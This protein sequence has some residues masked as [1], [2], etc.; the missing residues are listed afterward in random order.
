MLIN[1][2]VNGAINIMRKGVMERPELLM[3]LEDRI[4]TIELKRIC[5]PKTPAFGASELRSEKI[6]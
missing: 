1:A 4:M 2:D 5:N 6:F 3:M